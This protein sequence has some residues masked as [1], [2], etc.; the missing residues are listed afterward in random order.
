MFLCVLCTLAATVMLF[1]RLS[2]WSQL[3][4]R[5]DDVVVIRVLL[6]LRSGVIQAAYL[7]MNK[8][9]LLL[10]FRS[11]SQVLCASRWLNI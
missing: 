7:R 6:Y 9:I 11:R 10:D 3:I 4:T 5:S 2:V 1:M 8:L